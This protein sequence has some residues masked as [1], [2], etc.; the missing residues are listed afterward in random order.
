[1]G[2]DLCISTIIIPSGKEKTTQRKI[3]KAIKEFKIPEL[4]N[5]IKLKIVASLNKDRSNEFNEFCAFWEGGLYKEFN[6][7]N[8]PIDDGD[9]EEPLTEKEAQTIMKEIALDFFACLDYRDVTCI[10]HKGDNIYLTGGM[11]WGDS[12]TESTETFQKFAMLPPK[13]LKAGGL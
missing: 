13:I 8:M 3:M 9:G 11:S 12:P 4:G 10:S 7:N 2:A 6:E 1:M 5:N